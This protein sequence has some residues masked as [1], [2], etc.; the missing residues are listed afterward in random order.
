MRR[1]DEIEH[2]HVGDALAGVLCGRTAATLPLGSV[3]VS[4]ERCLL[5]IFKL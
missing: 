4:S 2:L 5:I 1:K 3:T